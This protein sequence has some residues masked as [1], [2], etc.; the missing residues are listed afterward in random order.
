MS[1]KRTSLAWF[2]LIIGKAI[3]D[4]FKFIFLGIFYIAKTIWNILMFPFEKKEESL[5]H[6][7][8][9]KEELNNIPKKKKHKINFNFLK[10]HKPKKEMC[11]IHHEKT[12]KGHFSDFR[13]RL[14]N[15]SLIISIVGR[16]GSGKSA[17]GFSLLE[18]IYTKTGRNAFV[19][20]VDQKLIPRWIGS[21]ERIEDV[22]NNSLLLIDEGAISFSS[23]ESMSKKNRELGKLLA[24]ARHKDLTLIFITQNT[25][26]MDKNVLNL[27]DT[28]V[29]K[30][31]SLLQEKM[32]RSAM[33]DFYEKSRI[34]LDNIQKNKRK[35]Y[36][37]V[38]DDDF[39]G[40]IKADL[41]SFWSTKISK[42]HK[43]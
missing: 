6:K 15:T 8:E 33:K 25:G 4:L 40:L 19:M 28:L 39:E 9:N 30:E 41:P 17:L 3:L 13:S 22:E 1:R 43:K 18:N 7:K 21:V 16:R 36:A 26:M 27:T 38:F 2:F 23:R 35:A 42:S 32:E 12:I 37:Y 10:K 31:G 20:G 14:D 24:V 5:D 29:F 11:N 34:S